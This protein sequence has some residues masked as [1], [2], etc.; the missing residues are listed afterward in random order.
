MAGYGLRDFRHG[1]LRRFIVYG[2]HIVPGNRRLCLPPVR[3][4]HER[5][6]LKQAGAYLDTLKAGE[7]EV[8]TLRKPVA[9]PAV[10]A[11]FDLC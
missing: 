5:R 8:I 11:L 10:S 3:A 9:N 1:G 2:G 7:I 4:K 6:Q